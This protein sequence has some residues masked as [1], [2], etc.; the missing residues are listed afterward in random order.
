MAGYKEHIEYLVDYQ[1]RNGPNDSMQAA[2]DLMIASDAAVA[3]SVKIDL[4]PSRIVDEEDY[5]ELLR[6]REREAL[7]KQLV[8]FYD[9]LNGSDECWKMER[10][11]DAVREFKVEVDDDDHR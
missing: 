1:R 5:Q 11:V 2:V 7:V 6:F 9:S 10:Y 4:R 3:P 8:R